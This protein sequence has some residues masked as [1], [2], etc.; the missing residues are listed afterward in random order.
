MGASKGKPKKAKKV[1]DADVPSVDLLGSKIDSLNN[2]GMSIKGLR[3]GLN[4]LKKAR[5]KEDDRAFNKA[6]NELKDKITKQWEKW[7]DRRIELNLVFAGSLIE[8]LEEKKEDMK[9]QKLTLKKIK[10]HKRRN[11][12][13]KAMVLLEELRSDL[14]AISSNYPDTMIAESWSS[15]EKALSSYVDLSGGDKMIGEAKKYFKR[16]VRLIDKGDLDN[17]L[18]YSNLLYTSIQSNISEDT[19]KDR[20]KVIEED[21]KDLVDTMEEFKKYGIENK[22]LE[23][24][25]NNLERM[26]KGKKTGEVQTTY[27][28]LNKNVSRFEKEFFRRKGTVSLLEADDLINE[29][30]SLIDLDEESEKVNAL[31]VDQTKMSP[32]KFMEESGSLLENVRST[33][34]E[35][36]E[37]QVKERVEKIENSLDTIS[38]EDDRS[39][40]IELKD[41]VS[42]ALVSRDITEA[43]EYLSLAE[44][45][46]G[47]ADDEKE[48][49]SVQEDYNRF[50]TDYEM[51]LNEDMELEELK[52]DMDELERM[53]LNDDLLSSGVPEK[54]KEAEVKIKDKIVNVRKERLNDEKEKMMG[55]LGTLEVPT[56]R[57]DNFQNRFTELESMLDSLEEEEYQARVGDI[58]KGIDEEISGFFRDNYNEWSKELLSS[59]EDLRGQDIEVSDL[60]AKLDDAG[61]HYRERDYLGSGQTLRDLKSELET[62]ENEALIKEVEEQIDSAEFLFDEASRSGVDVE[63]K[64][65]DLQMAKGLLDKGE[66]KEAGR[67]VG[68]IENDVKNLWK[69]QKRSILQDDLKE[70]KGYITESDRLGLDI[71]DAGGL[72]EE[73]EDLFKEDKLDEVNEVVVK[74]RE[75]IDTGRSQYYSKGA[76]ESINKLK[77]EISSMEE[78]GINSLESETL[79]IEAER[80]FMQ[81]EYEK[82][83]SVTLDI[84][85]QLNESKDAYF[86]EQIPKEMDSVLKKIGRL[87][88]MGLETEVAREYVEKAEAS[89]ERD[90]LISALDNVNKARE[91]SDEI[92]KSHISL[93]IP[94]TIVDVQK[95]IEETSLEGLELDDVKDMLQD[96]EG[97]FQNEDYDTAMNTIEEAQMKFDT[98]RED[99]F[100]SQYQ[101]NLDT[102]EDIMEKAT[103]SDTELELSRDNLNMAKDAYER[104]DYESSY[105]LMNRIVNFLERSKEEKESG[106]RREVVQTYYDEVKTLL[107]VSEGE[108]IETT[109]ERELFKLAGEQM[110]KGD[111]DQ[112]EH[113]LEG[114]KVSLNE[115]R[116]EMKKNLIESSI[117]T[118]EI[119]LKNMNEMGVNTDKE[120][121]LVRQLKEALRNGDLDL[122]DEINQKLTSALQRNQ[123]PVLVQRVQRDLSKLRA[124]IIDAKRNGLEVQQAKEKLS[125]AIELFELGDVESSLDEVSKGNEVLDNLLR[126][127]HEEEYL[128]MRGNLLKRVEELKEMSIPSDDEED[129]MSR[130]DVS[131]QEE[132]IEKAKEMIQVAEIG[133][134]AKLNSFQS[135]TAES[136]IEQITQYLS[137]LEELGIDTQDLV[138]VFEEAVELHNMGEDEKAVPKFSSILELGE[139]IRM[140]HELDIENNRFDRIKKL[141]QDLR[142]VGYKGTKKINELMDMI[143]KDIKRETPDLESIRKELDEFERV[144]LEKKEPH[145]DA[146]VKKHIK[147]AREALSEF[148]DNGYEDPDLTRMLRDAGERFRNGELEKAD[149]ISLSVI[150]NIEEYHRRESGMQLKEEISQVK[151]MLTRLKTL[152]SNVSNAESLLSR[153]E[154]ALD[155]SRIEN[156]EKLIGS[157]RQSIKDIVKRNMRETALETIEFTDAMIHYLLD[158][159]SG[160]S[161][162]IKPAEEKLDRARELFK[163]KKFKAAK[164]LSEEARDMVE[165]LDLQNIKQFLY[166][167]RSMQADEM[168]RDVTHR[169]EEL[170]SK[171]LDTS[172]ARML[173]ENA[174][175]NFEKDEFEKGR[176]MVT[177]ARIMLSELDQQSLRNKAFDELNDAHVEILSQ[178]K[179]GKNISSAHKTYNS[180]KEAFSLREY[181]KSLLLS[182]RANYQAR[183]AS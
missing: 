106:K 168:E 114:V 12:V 121:E 75:T 158:N 59:I 68:Q 141:Y 176:Q 23:K 35:N 11:E 78:M 183:K 111:F 77:D 129:I 133:A 37:G 51:L 139:E 67:L 118:S 24:D 123:G 119:L 136:Y 131:F 125:N 130:A 82:A 109:E 73:A 19:A 145:M 85:E 41:K 137:E 13:K 134:V 138:K 96:A 72:I 153:A 81:E 104:G 167:F 79:L 100:R 38:S 115:K 180:A 172:K 128:K 53:F 169:L 74:A 21:I 149:E 182:K 7:Q 14:D 10:D 152:G 62:I 91:V 155:E 99:Y 9:Q 57:L 52:E 5:K 54:V 181:K 61:K 170:I 39:N 88:A 64:K 108:N 102:V 95:Q 33:L 17:S 148:K 47:Q 25:L 162:D 159:F 116:M 179:K 171:G 93:T 49:L 117:Q 174:K 18:V 40:I 127:Y 1:K 163:E 103:G 161:K 160:I 150:E 80:L 86:Q 29:Y 27:K 46:M 28:R 89:K 142:S 173:F 92:F 42:N 58:K 36:F 50:L 55:L 63:G 44:S 31:K 135:S 71:S 165:Q 154:I 126:E 6:F 48:L 110:T 120:N 107:A 56:D 177:L 87:E 2:L 146:L 60:Q 101:N 112:A 132:D 8:A 22:S 178:K 3:S 70:L 143:E 157:V 140:L 32:K 98:K 124:R 83:Y 66:A 147:E 15:M 20:F 90:D 45:I 151:Q 30:G 97:L 43:M 65:K 16:M 156:A 26:V 113:L 175:E 94:E 76:M 84:R 105:R 144:L 69:E 122:C 34:F 166:V 4:A 164:S